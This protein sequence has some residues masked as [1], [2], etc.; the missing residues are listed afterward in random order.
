[1][2]RLWNYFD[3]EPYLDNPSLFI[4]NRRK[5]RSK[6]K[7][8]KTRRRDSKGR[9]L[10]IR[11]RKSTPH[12]RSH[13]PN[14]YPK[15]KRSTSRRRVSVVRHP[16]LVNPRRRHYRKH[17]RHN[18]GIFAM[19][20]LKDTAYA[21][22]G[23]VGVPFIEGFVVGYLPTV[24]DPTMNKVLRY[25]VKIGSAWGLSWGV[26]QI[27]GKEA[28]KYVL[29]GGLAYVGVSLVKEFILPATSI[30]AA[31]GAG[32]Y[33][34]SQ[35]L[36]GRYNGVTGRGQLGSSMTTRTADRLNPANRF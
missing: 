32:R 16:A 22:G 13:A 25:A 7:M 28:A 17:Y 36:L 21:V 26:K 5:K 10:K 14:I 29:I 24:T 20:T 18:P 1:M 30:S 4:A 23:F 6:A 19:S 11:G 3:G 27:G 9:F 31:S 34:Q 33:L 8:A 15:R 35:P 12:R 2:T